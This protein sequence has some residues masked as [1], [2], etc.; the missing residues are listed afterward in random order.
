MRLCEHANKVPVRVGP[1]PPPELCP[2]RPI[3]LFC[4]IP[5]IPP[6]PQV[7]R[8]PVSFSTGSRCELSTVCPANVTEI[9]PVGLLCDTAGAVPGSDGGGH[10]PENDNDSSEIMDRQL[11][12]NSKVFPKRSLYRF[13]YYLKKEF[14]K[15][16]DKVCFI[17]LLKA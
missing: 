3:R 5:C 4:H 1:P 17:C 12:Q 6:R 7:L 14:P 10:E 11:E 16:K 15:L 9:L 2:L 13:I 8:R